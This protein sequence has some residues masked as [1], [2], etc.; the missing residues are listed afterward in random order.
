M[1][2]DV[3]SRSKRAAMNYLSDNSTP[4]NVPYTP[5]DT[6]TPSSLYRKAI[7]N[8]T[9]EGSFTEF[10]E[11]YNQNKEKVA[12]AVDEG[13]NLGKS[14][15]SSIMDAKS[16]GYFG[17]VSKDAP[18]KPTSKELTDAEIKAITK[19]KESNTGAYL[20]V[21]AGLLLTA[22]IIVKVVSKNTEK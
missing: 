19:E 9:F 11:Y 18:F 17:Y 12:K 7:K 2:D 21:G 16:G 6:Q 8:K 22:F 4:D 10:L 14:L 15:F 20:L 3:S 5:S 13:I 1:L